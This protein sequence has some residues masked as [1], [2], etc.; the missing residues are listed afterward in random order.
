MRLFLPLLQRSLPI[1]DSY[2]KHF[3]GRQDCGIDSKNLYEAPVSHDEEVDRKGVF[4]KNRAILLEAMT[5]GGRHGFDA[6]FKP[7]GGVLALIFPSSLG[8]TRTK[9][10]QKDV[11]TDG[12][13]LQKSA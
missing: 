10:L 9:S 1:V 3:E 2:F 11:N 6:P 4:C 12:I 8:I 13:R 7:K 5:G